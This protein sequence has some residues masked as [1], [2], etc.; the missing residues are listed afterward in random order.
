[1]SIYPGILSQYVNIRCTKHELQL[2]T[3]SVW[4]ATRE[5]NEK[6]QYNDEIT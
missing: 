6:N 4:L 1:M 3:Y 2:E 5:N